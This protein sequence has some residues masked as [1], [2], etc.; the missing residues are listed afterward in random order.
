[1]QVSVNLQT[2]EHTIR[3]VSRALLEAE[4]NQDLAAT[5][6]FFTEKTILQPPGASQLEGLQALRSFLEEFFESRPTSWL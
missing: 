5:M 2:E 1:M 6:A 3:E 4:Q